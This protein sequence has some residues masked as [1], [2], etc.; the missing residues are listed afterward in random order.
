MYLILRDE[1]GMLYRDREY[2]DLFVWRGQ[3][4]ES[5]GMLSLVTVMQFAEGLTDRQ[6][7]EA[8][9]SRIDWKYALGLALSDPGFH[10]SV[11]GD[12]RQRVIEGG[13]E[14]QLLDG[15]LVHLQAHGWVKARG[16]QRTDSSHVLAVVRQLNRLECIGES[17]RQALNDLAAVAPDWLLSQVTT[18][19]FDLYGARF[20]AYR[21]P[22]EQAE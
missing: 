7:A 18:D 4:A 2:A 1:V 15:M 9:R 22:K 13:K 17:M 11:L 16:R 12:F 20:E 5:P 3:A 14:G 19:W 10:H 8:V 21:L 6:A